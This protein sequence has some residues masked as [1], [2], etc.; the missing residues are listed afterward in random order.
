VA[1]ASGH[2]QLFVHPRVFVSPNFL[3]LFFPFSRL[4]AAASRGN[5]RLATVGSVACREKVDLRQLEKGGKNWKKIPQNLFV[6]M[7][8]AA[9]RA[10]ELKPLRRRAP[11]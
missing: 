10:A 4:A 9:A 5:L 6:F 8:R 3:Y 7:W 2:F 11:G 1:A